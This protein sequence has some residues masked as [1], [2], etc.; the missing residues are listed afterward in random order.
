MRMIAD[1]RKIMKKGHRAKKKKR[2]STMSWIRMK[3]LKS[4]IC[5]DLIKTFINFLYKEGI[6]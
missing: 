5:Q 3:M 1:E 6:Q 4:G 2:E